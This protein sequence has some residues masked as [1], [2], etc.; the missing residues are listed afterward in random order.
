MP[1]RKKGSPPEGKI[2]EPERRS[3]MAAD[4]KGKTRSR[5]KPAAVRPRQTSG[6]RRAQQDPTFGFPSGPPPVR[7]E[8]HHFWKQPPNWFVPVL[9]AGLVV[10]VIMLGLAQAGVIGGKTV[11]LGAT[12]AG[13]GGGATYT[14]PS[15]QTNGGGTSDV[16]RLDKVGTWSEGNNPHR[17][18]VGGHGGQHLDYYPRPGVKSVS[19]IVDPIPNPQGVP[20]I[21]FGYGSIWEGN[22]SECDGFDWIADATAYARARLDSGHSGLVVHNGEVV[23]NV[24][25]LSQSEIDQLVGNFVTTG[26]TEGGS[27]PSATSCKD[28]SREDHNPVVGKTWSPGPADSW[29]IVNF[30]TNEKGHDQAER[31]LLLQPGDHPALRG[32]GAS[33]S[34]DSSCESTVKAEFAKNSLPQ[35]TLSQ[36]KSEGLVA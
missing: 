36:L 4:N 11:N 30:W 28:A 16:C 17:I 7:E 1:R 34:W 13:D 35:V 8:V 6:R 25:N 19:Y 5:R 22:G 12:P 18:E 33:F 31:K 29:R 21:V 9:I 26:S 2:R 3:K 10:A 24:G 23:A 14:P 15:G 32:G 20:S 27:A